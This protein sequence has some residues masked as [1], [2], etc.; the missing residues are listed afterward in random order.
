MPYQEFK[1]LISPV[2]DAGAAA[3]AQW[4]V[5][6]LDAPVEAMVGAKD[7]VTPTFTREQLRRLRNPAG[8]PNIGQ[9]KQISDSV[10]QSVMTAN[11]NA[12]LQAS[13]VVAKNQKDGLRI[14]VVTEDQQT[15][16][17]D[18]AGIRL[19]ELPVEA[20]RWQGSFLATSITTP[21]SRSFQSKAD[22][23]PLEVTLPDL[24]CWW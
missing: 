16:A 6:V 5:R 3:A 23:R 14:I 2:V 12:A 18:P 7:K 1:I 11:I 9:L 4:A 15:A 17:A 20:F 22:D 8:W 24:G 13:L 10:W 19:S 21:V